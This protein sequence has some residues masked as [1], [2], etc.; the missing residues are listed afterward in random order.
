M[1]SPLWITGALEVFN[2]AARHHH[3]HMRSNGDRETVTAV[4]DRYEAAATAAA[5]LGFTG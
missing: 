2:A 1:K 4:L 5:E 3:S